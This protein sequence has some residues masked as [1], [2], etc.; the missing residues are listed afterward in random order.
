MKLLSM[1]AVIA[2]ISI[3]TGCSTME[4]MKN[5]PMTEYQKI[6]ELPNTSQNDVYEGA[7]QWFAKSFRD[8]NSVLKYQ[9]KE[10]GVII[11]K[12]NTKLPCSGFNC[13][14]SPRDLQFTVKVDSKPNRARVTFSDL[15]AYTPAQYISGVYNPATTTPLY[16]DADK[17]SAQK[18]FD[19]TVSQFSSDVK[20]TS[21]D[22]DNW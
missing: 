7:R 13:L 15:V 17:A 20:F 3:T 5:P 6:V 9:D 11:G 1:G 18:I 21:V 10:T 2:A 12:G 8:S 4:Q 19:E 16:F 22:N 14:G